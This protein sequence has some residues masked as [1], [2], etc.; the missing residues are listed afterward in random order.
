MENNKS[1]SK[2]FW[3]NIHEILPIGNQSKRISLTDQNS[4]LEI[5]VDNTAEFVNTF[6]ANIGPN[7]AKKFN[8]PWRYEGRDAE[9]N[10]ENVVTNEE[11]VLKYCREINVNKASCIDN[12]SSRIIKDAFI[13]QVTRL[14]SLLNRSFDS[15]IFP[16]QWKLAKVIPLY[17][18]G[19]RHD[20]G[21][22]RP[23]SLLPLPSKII[24]K[25]VH[26]RLSSHLEINK[27]LDS[28]QG[29]FRKNHSTI[30][31]V[32]KLTNYL[33]NGINCREVTLACFIDMAK[34]FD[35]VNHDI[36]IQKL[37]KLG[38][39]NLLLSWIK[40]YLTQRKQCTFVNGNTSTLADI[41]CGVPQGS[42]LGP[43]FFIIYVNDIAIILTSCKHLLYA[44][45]TDL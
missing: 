13:I 3:K 19:N 17:K 25:I 38:I 18:G 24:E 35:T 14:T 5:D 26:T 22:Y 23:V 28:K 15:G 36:L 7:L 9:V 32:S 1:D 27:L 20:V 11:E 37:S 21:N 6:F 8:A 30:D 33:F 40:N 43:L 29:G 31:T 4:N 41:L 2:K 42:I 44:D 16:N 10:I 12:I 39:K 34:A 45:D